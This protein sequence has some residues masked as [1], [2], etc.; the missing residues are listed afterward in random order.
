MKSVRHWD[1]SRTS[2]FSEWGACSVFASLGRVRERIVVAGAGAIAMILFVGCGIFSTRSYAQ[3]VA[4]ADAD[5]APGKDLI[6]VTETVLNEE[7]T[8]L[9]HYVAQPDDSFKWSVVRREESFAG[10]LYVVDLTSQTWLRPDEVDRPQWRH[11]LTVFK[12]KGVQSDKALMMVGGGANGRPAPESLDPQMA[13]IASVTGS[14]VAELKSVPN[15]PLIFHGDGVPRVEDDLIGYTWDQYIKTGDS[16]WPARLPM[17]KSVVRAMDTV[18]ALMASEDGG[19]LSITGFVVAG[20]SKRGWTAWMTAAV[21]KR[22]VGIAPIVIDVLNMDVSMRNHYANYGFWAPAVKDY[23]NHRIMQRRDTERYRELLQLEDPFAYRDRFT[24]PKCIINATGDQFFCPDSSQ[25]YFDQLP[26]EK[27][28]CYVPNAD[29]SLKDS[30]ALESLISFHYSIVHDVPRP[31]FTWDHTDDGVI[32]VRCKTEPES[33][34]LWQ[35]YNP[36]GRDFRLLTIGKAFEATELTKDADGVY[37]AKVDVPEKGWVA[38]F[39]Q[40]EFKNGTP[41]PLRL[42][43]DVAV[44]P[45]DRPFVDKVIPSDSE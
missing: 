24:M 2:G 21:D 8:A 33:V 40:C 44:L 42:T 27:N 15:Q 34:K 29:H 41:L 18:Q 43:T 3:E 39:V 20:A 37:R 31:E 12:P 11:W 35:A 4:V 22:V 9:D 28:L 38:A 36:E 13:V 5:V 23:V 32:E 30:D 19:E 7:L 14:V 16:R 10:T 6:G 17:V 45:E 26:G 1:R 25:F